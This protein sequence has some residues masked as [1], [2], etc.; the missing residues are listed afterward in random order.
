LHITATSFN[1]RT[2][3]GPDEG[4][5][6]ARVGFHGDMRTRCQTV[7]N[8][9]APRPVHALFR[10][11]PLGLFGFGASAG[12]VAGFGGLPLWGECGSAGIT[13]MLPEED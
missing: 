2:G 8:G 12:S 9:K 1:G 6:N 7:C 5:V 4:F 3:I 10:G 11:R 13:V